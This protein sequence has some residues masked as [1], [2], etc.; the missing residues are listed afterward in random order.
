M[1]AR[2][3]KHKSLSHIPYLYAIKKNT[4]AGVKTYYSYLTAQGVRI[5][6]GTDRDQAI[7]A[8]K[9]LNA[10]RTND[11][12]L[13][14]RART[15]R[16][17]KA[18]K[19]KNSFLG[20]IEKYIKN[21]VPTLDW[22]ARTANEERI[23][24]NKIKKQF[25]HIN[26]FGDLSQQEIADYLNGIE[27][28]GASNKMRSRL[29]HIYD[30]AVSSGIVYENIVRRILPRKIAKVKRK[31]MTFEQYKQIYK[32]AD[33]PIKAA[34]AISLNFLQRRDDVRNIERDSFK[35]L[36]DKKYLAVAIRKTKN[37]GVKAR[38]SIS[39]DLPA[40]HLGKTLG[41]VLDTIE[42]DLISVKESPYFVN[43]KPDRKA[44]SA[45]KNHWAQLSGDQITDG[46]N[47][48]AE[49]AGVFKHMKKEQRP[50]FHKILSLGEYMRHVEL[51]ADMA[52]LQQMRGHTTQRMTTHYLDGYDW[53]FIK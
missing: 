53:T 48:A 31:D 10:E 23:R 44:K 15:K 13:I 35:Q 51:D 45:I 12:D 40:V 22:S 19:N 36:N 20:Y 41:D 7:R 47:E 25:D 21:I 29:V 28:P 42:R 24:L 18:V 6:F 38:V 27:S 11:I 5:G 50:T 30:H 4:K 3:N 32:C 9:Q 34:M 43:H 8:A 52:Q 2:T 16:I 49:K 26:N 17:D 37:S 46:F 1:R 14:Q 33:K 39:L